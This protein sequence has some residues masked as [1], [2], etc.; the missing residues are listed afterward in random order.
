MIRKCSCRRI[1]IAMLIALTLLLG[2]CAG[3]PQRSAVTVVPKTNIPSGG[4][5]LDAKGPSAGA[6]PEELIQG[7]LRAASA[8]TSDDYRVAREY[9][10]PEAAKRWKPAKSVSIFSDSDSIEYSRTPT[11]AVVASV[12][13]LANLDAKGRY[14]SAVQGSTISQ[15]FS[16][17]ID[18]DG[19]WRI[20]ELDDSVLMV[21]TLFTSLYVRS[22]LYFLNT[23][24][25]SFVP[26][27][28]WYPRSR[29]L[30]MMSE[31]LISA[32]SEWLSKVA[33]SVFTSTDGKTDLSVSIEGGVARVNLPAEAASLKQQDLG[34]LQAQFTKTFVGSGLVQDVHLLAGGA[35]LEIPSVPDVQAYPYATVPAL[36]IQ[37]GELV[38]IREGKSAVLQPAGVFDAEDFSFLAVD[39]S[40]PAQWAVGEDSGRSALT[41]LNT[42]NGQLH[43]L[44]E[45][46]NLARPSIDQAGWLW[47]ADAD[48]PGVLLAMNL[49]SEQVL[50]FNVPDFA[51]STIDR[52]AVSRENSRIVVVA[53]SNSA[54]RMALYGAVRDDSGTPLAVGE[55]LWFGQ[56]FT[57]VRD[58]AWVSELRMLVLGSV[59]RDGA[60]GLFTLDI[61]GLSEPVTGVSSVVALTAG[62]SLDSALVMGSDGTVKG[63]FGSAWSNVA[64]G[65]TAIAFPG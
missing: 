61:G 18:A 38:S 16:L 49:Q 45:G 29:A 24:S 64:T 13:A 7:F 32:P 54:T 51:D 62:R 27:V 36:A 17:I 6:T 20:S 56:N 1:F 55:P 41:R 9:L 40:M 58:I 34:F 43:T 4:V 15:K 35:P 57:D 39:Y 23:A 63:Y 46:R 25:S 60:Q 8:G 28:R 37:N 21:Q 11:G 22:P 33:H 14:T 52:I 50:K 53:K 10:T 42:S 31:A 48:S 65:V 5:V 19:Q 44:L 26:D 2:A 3:L 30:A 47:T 12:P 59:G